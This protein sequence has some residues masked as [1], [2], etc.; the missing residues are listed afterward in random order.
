MNADK[1]EHKHFKP[2]IALFTL[3]GKHL[4]LVD[5]FTYQ[6]SLISGVAWID[7]DRLSILCKSDHSDEKKK[8]A[9]SEVY[10]KVIFD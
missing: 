9:S 7:M 2:V 8:T 5:W 3:S 1:I 4:K 10:L 6:H